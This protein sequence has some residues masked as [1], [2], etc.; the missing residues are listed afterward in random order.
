MRKR[1]TIAVFP[2]IMLL[3]L[4]LSIVP[5][6][7]SSSQVSLYRFDAKGGIPGPPPKE[8]KP[9]EEVAVEYELFI[10][11]DYMEG[12]E[13]NSIVLDYVHTYYLER[14]INVTFYVDDV[15]PLDPR[16]GH[17]FLG[18]RGSLQRSGR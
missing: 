13:P 10:E 11:I 2:G 5:S 14:G 12:H 7:A 16:L 4:S 18:Y 17:R 15:V 1:D 9:P 3:L 6:V 8:P